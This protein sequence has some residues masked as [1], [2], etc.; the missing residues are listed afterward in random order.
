MNVFEVFGTESGRVR[1]QVIRGRAA[2][3]MMDDQPD[4]DARRL[5]GALPG[6]AE[7]PR[8]VVGRQRFRFADVNLRRLEAQRRFDHRVEDVDARHDHQ[9]DGAPFSFG[10]GDHRRQQLPLLVG[11][12]RIACGIVGHVHAD[13]PHRHR[14]DVAI[15]GGAQRADEVREHVRLADRHKEIPRP[16]IH[17]PQIHIVGRQ[18]LEFVEAGV[19]ARRF[20]SHRPRRRDQRDGERADQ[21][22]ARERGRIER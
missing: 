13:E 20:R 14:H 2:A 19:G 4:V 21:R 10:G 1:A 15:A 9:P 5:R 16:R 11:R 3:R 17:L 22:E 12:A 6:V 8:L 18:Q 7:Q